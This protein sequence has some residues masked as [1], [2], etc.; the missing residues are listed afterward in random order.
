LITFPRGTSIPLSAGRT[1]FDIAAALKNSGV[2]KNYDRWPSP[3]WRLGALA[4]N[5]KEDRIYQL[6]NADCL[7][8]MR[9]MPESSVD[10]VVCDPPYFLSF[11]N[12]TWDTAPSPREQQKQHEA[13]AREALRVLKPG[14]FLLAFGGTRTVHRLAC[15]IEDVGFEI[16]DRILHLRGGDV[17]ESPGELAW[18]YGSG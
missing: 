11:M 13:W 9:Q 16:R 1:T 10:S 6:I 14:G 17:T 4:F 15:A 12:H 5:Q 18:I 2:G 3:R 8:A 7:D